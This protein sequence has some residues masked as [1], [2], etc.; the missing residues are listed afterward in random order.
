[1]GIRKEALKTIDRIISSKEFT[2]TLAP[3]LQYL[4]IGQ[5]KK[6]IIKNKIE[7]IQGCR[8][9]SS[10]PYRAIINTSN[11]CNYRCKICEIHFLHK[12]YPVHYPN[13]IDLMAFK[14]MNQILENLYLLEF[15]GN[16]GEPL[17]NPDFVNIVRYIKQRFGTR[18]FLN[19]NGSL[20]NSSMASS[21]ITE[22]FD[23]I[24][25]SL[26]AASEETYSKLIGGDF[27]RVVDNIAT[28]SAIKK[29]Y[30]EKKPEIGI[31]FALNQINER[32]VEDIVCLAY[33]LKANYL[34][35]SHYYHGLNGMEKDISFMNMSPCGNY[36][37]NAIYDFAKFIGHLK[38]KE[39]TVLPKKRPYLDEEE[40]ETPNCYAPWNTIKMDGCIEYQNSHYISVCNRITLFRLDYTEFDFNGFHETLWNHPYLQYMRA[41]VNSKEQNPICRLCKNP[42]NH[43]LRNTDNVEYRRRRDEA[44]QQ[45]WELAESYLKAP[46]IKG[47]HIIKQNP[48]T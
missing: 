44:M 23:E 4:P 34:Q 33:K 14:N 29:Q 28:I 22:K 31:A 32:E 27:K 46:E 45:F 5:I 7:S 26:H 30:R 21:L 3:V 47:I 42:E 13:A 11:T 40:P 19:T 8:I 6:N 35:V 41:T 48:Y 24:L 16:V 38:R 25:I 43:K 9:V 18:L 15:F 1:M 2:S 36:K 10:S 37:V 20:L 12:K 39:L 17:T